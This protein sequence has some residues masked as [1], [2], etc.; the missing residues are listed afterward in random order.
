MRVSS[1]WF[2]FVQNKPTMPSILIQAPSK[3]D[4][5]LLLGLASKLGFKSF[6]LTE[7]ETRLLARQK[8]AAIVEDVDVAEA[9]SMDE[10]NEIV[11]E[12]RTRR[13]V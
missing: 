4:L 10:I 3:S 1:D 13:Y 9:P 11:E 8:L 12:V 6:L 5:K 7:R 2:T